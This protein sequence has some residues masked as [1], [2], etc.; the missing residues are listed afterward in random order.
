MLAPESQSDCVLAAL[1]PLRLVSWRDLVV[2]MEALKAD[3]CFGVELFLAICQPRSDLAL[4]KVPR[5][6]YFR[7]LP[8]TSGVSDSA[9]QKMHHIPTVTR[10]F[11]GL[12]S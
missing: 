1:E 5:I 2:S 6:G 10:Q 8:E 7:N 9:H 11:C 4:P 12:R 3:R